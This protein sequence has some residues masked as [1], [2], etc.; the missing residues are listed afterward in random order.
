MSS[1][2]SPAHV[3]AE[4]HT[5]PGTDWHRVAGRTSCHRRKRGLSRHMTGCSYRSTQSVQKGR[6]GWS[7]GSGSQGSRSR[8]SGR[9]GHALTQPRTPWVAARPLLG[10]PRVLAV[11]TPQPSRPDS[12]LELLWGFTSHVPRGTGGD[13]HPGPA[14]VAGGA[15]PALRCPSLCDPSRPAGFP[16]GRCCP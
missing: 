4:T 11:Y 12:L 15:S 7:W 2:A 14:P 8:G 3:A 9:W 6:E 16:C 1:G 13:T 10:D 5:G